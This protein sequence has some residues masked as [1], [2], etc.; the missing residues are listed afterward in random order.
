MV[1]FIEVL[2]LADEN[3]QG[4]GKYRLTANSDE[5]GGFHELCYHEHDSRDEARNCPD[6][7]TKEGLITGIPRVE[8]SRKWLVKDVKDFGSYHIVYF[9]APDGRGEILLDLIESALS[10]ADLIDSQNP[11][12]SSALKRQ[13]DKVKKGFTEYF[14]LRVEGSY[15]ETQNNDQQ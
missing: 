6:A 2:E 1:W 14:G 8:H 15:N 13:A 7:I 4:T 5:G 10:V 9:D 11:T 12:L 3:K